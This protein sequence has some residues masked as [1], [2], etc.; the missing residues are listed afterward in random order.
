MTPAPLKG[1]VH[2]SKIFGS[3]LLVKCVIQTI[4]LAP[5]DTESIAPKPPN[6]FPGMIQ[7]ARSPLDETWSPPKKKAE[8]C[9]PRNIP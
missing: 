7:L 3:P 5:V 2:L 9:P 6:I 8:R 4:I 1:K